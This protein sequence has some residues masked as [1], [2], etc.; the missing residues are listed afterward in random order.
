MAIISKPYQQ[1]GFRALQHYLDLTSTTRSD[2]RCMYACWTVQFRAI[3]TDASFVVQRHR[4]TRLWAPVFA[5]YH[6]PMLQCTLKSKAYRSP[7]GS[8]NDNRSPMLTLWGR[9]YTRFV[10]PAATHLASANRSTR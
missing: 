7:S 6:I 4:F 10:F 3:V 2:C 1:A 5:S 9:T 8:H